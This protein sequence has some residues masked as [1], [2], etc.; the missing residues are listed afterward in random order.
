MTN[1][2]SRA[3]SPAPKRLHRA[4]G[5]RPSVHYTQEI[6][7]EILERIASGERW[8]KITR[9][10][11]MPSRCTL[12]YWLNQD[13][14]FRAAYRR[15]QQA[16]ADARADKVLDIAEAATNE[17]LNVDK[18]H[19]TS[20]KWH[21]DRDT[22]LFGPRPDEPDLGAGRHIVIEV[23]RFVR[24]EREDGSAFVREVFPNGETR[25]LD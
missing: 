22:K 1:E 9:R 8:T 2:G 18:F 20:L 24:V 17:T 7:D 6:A 12:Y 23:R 5:K 21:V 16:G 4:K 3:P 11:G 13:P 15:A 10:R 25:D 14:E 19:V